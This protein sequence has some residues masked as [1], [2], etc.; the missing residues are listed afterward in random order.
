[1][2]ERRCDGALREVHQDL[3]SILAD[4]RKTYALF[5]WL[6]HRFNGD[7]F[8]GQGSESPAER[9]AAW[10]AERDAVTEE[11]LK[12]LAD[13]I[14]GRMDTSDR[15]LRLWPQYSFDT[16]P[17]EF[18]SSAYEDFLNEEK[19]QSKAFYTP[20]QLAFRFHLP[21]PILTNSIHLRPLMILHASSSH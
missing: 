16:I 5:R 15:Q 14:A 10:R 20:P 3:T 13:F 18:I 6:D 2:L 11:H 4:K 12:L 9:E 8:P 19:Y 1:M 7:L 21:H 17:L